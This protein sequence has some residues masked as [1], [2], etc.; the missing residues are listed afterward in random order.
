MSDLDLCYMPG[1]LL[2]EQFRARKLSP[3]ELLEAQIRRAEAVNPAVNAYTDTYY[4]E[5][6][7]QARL[8]EKVFAGKHGP[9][10][11]LEG[12]T[13]AVK[14]SQALKGKRTTQGSLAYR[15]DVA[16]ENS[17][18]SQRLLDAGA[19]VVAKTTTPEFCSA[20]VT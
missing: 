10:R 5:A 6:M 3:V 11:P 7:A 13:L 16:P 17:P 9:V 14:D 20:G 12:L 8:A 2:Q 1:F 4:D 15:D 18:T 19:I